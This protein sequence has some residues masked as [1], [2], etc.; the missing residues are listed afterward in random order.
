MRIL[1]IAPHLSTGGLPQYLCKKI[2]CLKDNN[3]IYCV[4]YAN[5]SDSFTVQR[6]KIKNI[7]KSNYRLLGDNK[8]ELLDIIEKIN[9]EIVFLEEIP[10]YFLNRSLAEKIY[11][12]TRNYKIIE[13]THDSSFD[14]NKK[15]FLPDKF[16]AISK[17]I[18]N[19]F[20]SLGIPCELMEYPV[21]KK[22]KLD[23]ILAQKK[24][25]LDPNKKHVINVG[26]FTSRK[27]QAEII[28]YAKKLKDYP[29]QFHFIGNQADNF[30]H[31]WQPLMENFPSNCKWWGERND[32]ELFYEASDLF[33]FT[34]RG[35]AND[36]ETSPLV[37][38]EA[39]SYNLT[40]LI[41]NLP[42]YLGMYD[43]YKN[44]KYLDF[45][46]LDENLAKIARAVGIELKTEELCVKNDCVFIVSSYPIDYSGT[47]STLECLDN[48]KKFN[49]PIILTSH[50]PIPETLQA[51]SDYCIYDKNNILTKHDFFSF[52]WSESSERRVEMN[53]KTSDNHSYHGPAVYTNYYN[54]IN[55]AKSL[56]FKEVICLNFDFIIKDAGFLKKILENRKN[57]KGYFCYLKEQEG[58]TLKTVFYSIDS[59][60]FVKNFPLIRTEKDYNDWQKTIA[61]PS[62]G[63]ENLYFHSLKKELNNFHLEGIEQF[64][65]DT[66]C[67]QVD[68]SSQVEYFAALPI[69]N[70]KNKLAIFFK[71]SHLLDNRLVSIEF[72]NKKIEKKIET[73]TEIL[74]T[75]DFDGQEF[76]I[77]LFVKNV[78]G[79]L[80]YKK[81]INIDK[82]YF[83]NNLNK[84]GIVIFKN[85]NN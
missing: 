68:S 57:K 8:N 12:K 20:S 67:C 74:E 7:L 25:G 29:I 28:E 27:N 48:L 49:L 60:L 24:L 61:C 19:I 63:L 11:S 31:Y 79:D 32:V 47:K 46:N 39:A 42:V 53:L 23:K 9:P 18:L 38:R 77:E 73:A 4:E 82:N 52:Y 80:I 65:K 3:E 70:Q 45:E 44:I 51:S 17:F 50:C 58:D 34:S 43:D 54:A 16:F 41:Y 40:S 21:E 5:H 15:I 37:I 62:N 30:K 69:K 78:N 71:S 85:E 13:T 75:T 22:E 14:I 83:E 1:F 6:D 64:Q 33:L 56:G 76:R 35:T 72:K 84:N 59:D 66:S 55:F 36:K 81:S 10:E 2:E 26:L